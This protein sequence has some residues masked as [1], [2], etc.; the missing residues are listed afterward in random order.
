MEADSV[1]RWVRCP[2]PARDGWGTAKQGANNRN[3]ESLGT[4][5]YDKRFQTET[6]WSE[7]TLLPP[8]ST[9]LI[10]TRSDKCTVLSGK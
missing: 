9:P 5:V 7:A 3:G 1:A 6:V 8:T 2:D 4:P 10:S